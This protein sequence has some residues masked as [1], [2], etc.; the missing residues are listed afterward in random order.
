[1]GQTLT[2][3]N[4]ISTDSQRTEILQ[5][6]IIDKTPVLL[7]NEK[8]ET[9]EFTACAV[10]PDG[11]LQ[12]HVPEGL[13][14][15]ARST[16]PY[17]ASFVIGSE[18]YLLEVRPF[19]S[20][21]LV[22]LKIDAF[23]HLQRRKNFRYKILPQTKTQFQIKYLN[24]KPVNYVCN[25]TDVSPEGFSALIG[26]DEVSLNTFD[27][28][29]GVI[30]CDSHPPITISGQ[31]K[32]LRMYGE[33]QLTLGVEFDHVSETSENAIFELIAYLQRQAF[34]KNAA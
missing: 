31:V 28:V 20:E 14:F 13:P 30:T 8:E 33:L 10:T 19:V 25:L 34:R 7:K 15:S 9:V 5:K 6:L 11:N 3:F 17:S 16:D 12:C 2:L 4:S 18:K 22:T 29:S 24:Y 23:F 21:N 27:K 1:M 32:N 26:M